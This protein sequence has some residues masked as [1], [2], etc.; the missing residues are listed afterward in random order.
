MTRKPFVE[1]LTS[2]MAV[3]DSERVRERLRHLD[4]VPLAEAPLRT[5]VKVAGEVKSTTSSSGGSPPTFEVVVTDGT[6][7]LLVVFTGRRR[8]AGIGP[9]R[10]LVLEGVVYE[11]RNRRRMMNPAYTL[12]A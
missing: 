12:L 11:E 2:P 5:Q 9:G 7:D 3:L 4:V 6:A 10:V 8:I 1:R